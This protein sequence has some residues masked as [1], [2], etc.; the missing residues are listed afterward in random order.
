[1]LII[2]DIDMKVFSKIVDITDKE[3]KLGTIQRLS[4]VITKTEEE[5]EKA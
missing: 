1:M 3:K 5:M 2:M 4:K